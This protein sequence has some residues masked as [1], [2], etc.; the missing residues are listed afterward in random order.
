MKGQTRPAERAQEGL[1]HLLDMSVDAI[2]SIDERDRI[3][4]WNPA[5][6]RVFGYTKA[7]ALKMTVSELMPESYREGHRNGIKRFVKTEQPALIGRT[8]EIEALRKDGAVF[9]VELNI[10][11]EKKDGGWIFFSIIRDITARRKNEEEIKAA[12][13]ML[14]AANSE[15]KLLLD[16]SMS[17]SHTIDMD[18]LLGGIIGTIT[19][20]ELF[21]VQKK[22]GIFLVEDGRMVLKSYIG[23]TDAFVELHR[24][25]K[26]GD[27]LCGT[28]AA[29]GEMIL[30]DNSD[31][32]PRHT[33]KSD[34]DSHGHIILPLKSG[35]VVLG[36]LYL[37]LSV[38]VE[39]TGEHRAM[40]SAIGGL[41]G[42]AINNSRLYEKTKELSLDDPLTGL[43][44]RRL[45][46]IELDRNMAKVKRYGGP[47]S[48]I[49]MDI[50]Y[51]KMYND[52][53]GHIEGDRLLEG[54]ARLLTASTREMDLIVRY[55]GEEFLALLPDTDC[56]T[57]A[58]V[59]ERIR[60]TVKEKAD[61]TVSL[62]VASYRPGMSNGS[63][64]I[65]LA[66]EA[67]YRAKCNGRN[68]V[69]SAP[70]VAL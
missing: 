3:I 1:N 68:R 45:L 23:H 58:V 27:C 44:N 24:G 14:A 31:T 21:K 56:D 39:L 67:L 63:E 22:G 6:E 53:R 57:A 29:S 28:A 20:L 49:M 18:A 17:I 35:G 25:M 37:Y 46:Y 13:A 8:V 59:A 10:A 16:V 42:V 32:D 19:R 40:L 5:A 55:G 62:G 11:A 47:L 26:V 9:S 33:I 7:E 50:D 52:T 51:F 60:K 61:V 66:D 34:I 12:S 70:A 54:F 30:S 15:L 4:L 41:I 43:A 38:G 65:S 36:V 69:E 2:V 64:L 48:V